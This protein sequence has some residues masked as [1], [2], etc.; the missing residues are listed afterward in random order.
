MCPA[1][2]DRLLLRT[3]AESAL[4]R[5]QPRH[6]PHRP[7]SRLEW[8]ANSESGPSTVSGLD[9]LTTTAFVLT[10]PLNGATHGTRR[11]LGHARTYD[12]SRRTDMHALLSDQDGYDILKKTCIEGH[13]VYL[14]N[15]ALEANIS[16]ELHQIPEHEYL[17]HAIARWRAEPTLPPPVLPPAIRDQAL[18]QVETKQRRRQEGAL[19]HE[20]YRGRVH[21]LVTGSMP[22]RM[23][24]PRAQPHPK[25]QFAFQR[26][27]IEK[28]DIF[29]KT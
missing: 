29:G 23:F 6:H 7:R 21:F 18:S 3:G 16:D 11:L 4:F 22:P 1:R 17:A 14:R 19:E 2:A 10:D 9:S 24:A 27:H 5:V 26:P 28:H 25:L 12:V 8:Q 13:T 20:G 15:Y